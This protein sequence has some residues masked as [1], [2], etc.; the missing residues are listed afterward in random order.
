MRGN[1]NDLSTLEIQVITFLVNAYVVEHNLRKWNLLLE[2]QQQWWASYFVKVTELQL[3]LLG[4]K[5]AKLQLPFWKS[6]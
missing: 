6:N 1:N 5:I 4:K 3:Q 2:M